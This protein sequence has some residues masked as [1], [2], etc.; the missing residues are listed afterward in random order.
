[1]L[2]LL[3]IGT[4]WRP[5][6]RHG[7]ISHALQWLDASSSP[8]AL[9]EIQLKRTTRHWIVGFGFRVACLSNMPMECFTW[10][11]R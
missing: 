4:I 9:I 7:K 2:M 5:C 6:T 1:M 8:V 3:H 10:E 11:A